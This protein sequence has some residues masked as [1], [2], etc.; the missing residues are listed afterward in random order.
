MSVPIDSSAEANRLL[1]N[2]LCC[3]YS[4]DEPDSPGIIAKGFR[5]VAST[6]PGDPGKCLFVP[7]N[8]AGDGE[9]TSI[10]II[11]DCLF[12]STRFVAVT[13]RCRV[14]SRFCFVDSSENERDYVL[15]AAIFCSGEVT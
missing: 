9:A 2:D 14:N 6:K 8:G 10:L 11:D 12:F 4:S 5:L 3:M 7:W 15:G 13:P 1:L